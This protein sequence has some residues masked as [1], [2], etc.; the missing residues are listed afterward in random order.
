MLRSPKI[1]LHVLAP[2]QGVPN[3]CHLRHRLRLTPLALAAIGTTAPVAASQYNSEDKGLP[4][5]A[6]LRRN[7]VSP[8][9][10]RITHESE[11]ELL[12]L[13]EVEDLGAGFALDVATPVVLALA[14][15]LHLH[16]EVVCSSPAAHRVAVS[17]AASSR[18]A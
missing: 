14:S 2:V 18:I 10:N 4:Q 17:R 11:L 15:L 7:G 3:S 16:R 5:L 13:T 12:A 8:R 9:F 6:L 1:E